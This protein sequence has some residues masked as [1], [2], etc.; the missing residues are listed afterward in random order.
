MF[1]LYIVSLRYCEYA[2][3]CGAHVCMRT[4]VCKCICVFVCVYVCVCVC[5]QVREGPWVPYF[6]NTESPTE[7]EALGEQNTGKVFSHR[8]G[9]V[10]Q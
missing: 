5:V 4:C 8:A 6:L 2:C 7:L 3:M 1:F 9:V 10:T